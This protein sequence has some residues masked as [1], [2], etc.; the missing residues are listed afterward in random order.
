ML[1]PLG[2]GIYYQMPGSPVGSG[3]RH[4]PALQVERDGTIVSQYPHLSVGIPPAAGLFNLLT[5]G[6]R[7]ERNLS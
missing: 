2:R 1:R 7:G 4:D 6:E 3:V 5:Q